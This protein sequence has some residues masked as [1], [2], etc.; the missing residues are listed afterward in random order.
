MAHTASRIL[1]LAIP[2]HCAV[3]IGMY[4]HPCTFPSNPLGGTLDKLA[5]SAESAGGAAGSMQGF[6]G[7]STS[8]GIIERMT[9]EPTWVMSLMLAVAILGIFLLVL[10]NILGATFGQVW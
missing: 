10:K 6:N 3:A 4:S 2:L 7:T 5:S 8:Q 1:T 9:R